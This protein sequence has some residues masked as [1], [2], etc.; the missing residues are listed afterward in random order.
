MAISDRGFASMDENKKKRI[1]SMGGKASGGSSSKSSSI[2]TSSRSTGSS[3]SSSPLTQT[4][5][6]K[7]GKH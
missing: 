6:S 7:G 2:G 3:G 4:D 5:R 1:Q